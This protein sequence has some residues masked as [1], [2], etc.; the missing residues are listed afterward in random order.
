MKRI[1]LIFVG[2]L[3][4][5]VLA[6]QAPSLA[7][8]TGG[9]TDPAAA[10]TQQRLITVTGTATVTSQ[11]DEAVVMLGVHT[12]ADSAQAALGENSAKMNK[13]LDALRG[14]GLSNDDLAT[15]NVS[16]NPQWGS[17]GQTVSGFQADNQVQATIHDMSNVGHVIDVAVGAGANVAGGVTFQVSDQNQGHTDALGRAIDNAKAKADAMASAAGASVGEVVTIT[18]ASA[19]SPGPYPMFA[20]GAVDAAS[21]P[22]NPPTIESQVS[23]T[24]TWALS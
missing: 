3:A 22:V 9:G 23:V 1:G 18:E 24:V 14:A 17:N 20:A 16:L 4:G 13:V 7:Q 10:T 21:T 12:E 8:A 15:T 11:P 5:A 6:M 2:V 19:P